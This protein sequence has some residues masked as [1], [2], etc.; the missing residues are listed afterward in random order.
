MGG[1]S[2]HQNRRGEGGGLRGIY[3]EVF[4]YLQ[5]GSK[6]GEPKEV[7]KLEKRKNKKKH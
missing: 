3:L 6:G 4:E 2:T 5:G 7:G 1:E